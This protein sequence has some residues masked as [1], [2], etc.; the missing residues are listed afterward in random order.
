MRLG[1][2]YIDVEPDSA[3]SLHWLTKS[4]EQGSVEA[5]R[6]LGIGYSDGDYAG[7]QKDYEKAA[8]WLTKAAEQGDAMAQHHLGLLYLHGYGVAQDPEMGRE[9]IAKAAEQGEYRAQYHLA[10]MYLVGLGDKDGNADEKE[11]FRWCKASAEQG[12]V[13]AQGM[14]ATMYWNGQGVEKDVHRAAQWY[15][16]AAD[17]GHPKAQHQV[18]VMYATG[19]GFEINSDKA[20]TYMHRSASQGYDLAIQDLASMVKQL[21]DL[22][23]QGNAAALN[24]VGMLYFHGVGVERDYIEAARYL[25]K[26]ADKGHENAIQ[27]LE[28]L[29]GSFKKEAENGDPEYQYAMGVMYLEGINVKKDKKMAKKYLKMAADQGNESAIQ[30]LKSLGK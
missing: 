21:K 15:L 1:I 5:Q 3:K 7:D 29:V 22:A 18:A 9:W 16:L 2:Y 10:T 28:S 14:L 20:F 17:A 19:E 8:H 13:E 23:E 4:A 25:K 30:A 6:Y 24:D 11:A 27:F 12:Y 26:A